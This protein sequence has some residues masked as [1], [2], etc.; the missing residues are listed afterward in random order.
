MKEELNILIQAQ[1]PLIYLITSEEERAEE[2]IS[3]ITQI[4]VDEEQ[5]QVFVWTVTHGIVDN[6]NPNR[7]TVQHNTVS[8]ESAI[9]WAIRQ[10]ESGIYILKIYILI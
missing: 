1:Y 8:P 4:Q 7:Q 3:N 6:G 5:R 9:E 10:R 2:A